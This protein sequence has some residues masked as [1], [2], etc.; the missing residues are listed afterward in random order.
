MAEKS[1]PITI[2][3]QLFDKHMKKGGRPQTPS[4]SH[5]LPSSDSDEHEK[6]ILHGE[7][8]S[9]DPETKKLRQKKAQRKYFEKAS[10]LKA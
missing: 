9:M 10:T 7:H 4:T 5:D 3:E 1:R 8:G 6:A 2:I